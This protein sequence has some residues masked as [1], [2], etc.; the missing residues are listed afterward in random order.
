MQEL[1]RFIEGLEFVDSVGGL[2]VTIAA[3]SDNKAYLLHCVE[4]KEQLTN[5]GGIPYNCEWHF[6]SVSDL[7]RVR[8]G[9]R[10]GLEELLEHPLTPEERVLPSGKIAETYTIPQS[11]D[12]N[13]N[14][15]TYL[16]IM[17]LL[18]SIYD[19]CFFA[20]ENAI[21]GQLR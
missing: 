19:N 21:T 3:S 14:P 16:R 13:E 2:T 10:S 7:S 4:G 1:K 12:E 15:V 18:D 5:L 6:P 9:I 8:E 17:K 11:P 20:G